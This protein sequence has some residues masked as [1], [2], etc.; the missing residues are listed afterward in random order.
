MRWLVRLLVGFLRL[1]TRVFFST[2]EVSGTDNVPAIGAVIFVGNHPNSLLDPI[3][4]LTTCGRP[5]CFAAKEVL[6]RGPL[7]PF[8]V[9]LGCVPVKRRQDQLAGTAEDSPAHGAPA[10]VD[11]DEAFDALLALLA[12][13]GAVGIFPEGISHTRPGLAPLKTGAARI[14][15]LARAQGTPVQIVPV[16][17]HYRRRDRMRS[18]VLVQFGAPIDVDA[19]VD[20]SVASPLP[21]S[22]VTSEEARRRAARELTATLDQALRALTI[23]TSDFDTLRVLEGV[24]RLYRPDHVAL[25][26]T[27]QTALLQRFIAY[28]EQLQDD[29][30]VAALYRDIEV[31]QH[32]LRLLGL[33]DADLRAGGTSRLVWAE[34]LVRHGF[35]LL[36]LLPLAVPGIVLHLP[37]LV[38]AVFAGA[39]LTDRGDVR[40]TI[41]MTVLTAATALVHLLVGVTVALAMGPG[42]AALVLLGLFLSAYA[43]IRVLERQ[44]DVRRGLS[45]FVALWHLD[46]ALERLAAQRERLRNR[47][48]AVV[49]RHAGDIA[50]IIP[51]EDHGPAP[52]LTDDDA[53]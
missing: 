52:W 35:F 9:L 1:V 21:S 24:R 33:G 36:V 38:A 28:W 18:R 14:A 10:R 30:E 47:L 44:A 7:R 23:N 41:K 12:Q 51:P 15:L 42:A 26:L 40:A 48:L 3:L 4:V 17:L 5:V 37:V 2:V 50:R 16:G 43:A 31:Y 46:R 29:P 6:F 49:D 39:A 19:P 25:S 32:S 22:A 8:L 34:R 53:D 20:A 11:N 13:G 27:A 45:T